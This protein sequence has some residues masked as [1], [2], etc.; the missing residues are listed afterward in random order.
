MNVWAYC[1]R[2][3]VL[4]ESLKVCRQVSAQLPRGSFMA[5]LDAWRLQFSSSL[6]D[7][8]LYNHRTRGAMGLVDLEIIYRGPYEGDPVIV[9]PHRPS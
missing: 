3:S 5:P 8:R 2:I 1:I 7:T 9:V 6:T 4:L